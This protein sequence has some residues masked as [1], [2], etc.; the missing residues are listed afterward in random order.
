MR[1]LIPNQSDNVVEIAG[2]R[3][4]ANVKEFTVLV[5][6]FTTCTLFFTLKETTEGLV[7]SIKFVAFL[8]RIICAN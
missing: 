5:Q 2:N 3:F 4:E 6:W 7:C 1:I 8:M